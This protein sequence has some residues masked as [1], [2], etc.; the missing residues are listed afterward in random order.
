MYL[1]IAAILLV[2]WIYL[3][4]I[5]RK[6]GTGLFDDE[7]EPEIAAR[8]YKILKIFLLGAGTSL[9]VSV[10]GIILHNVLEEPVTFFIGF[11]PLCLF[12]IATVG[13]LFIFLTGRRATA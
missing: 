6:R 13:G 9:A 2:V 1:L 8:R 4:F 3:I 12:I 11:V 5:I 7:V 10:F